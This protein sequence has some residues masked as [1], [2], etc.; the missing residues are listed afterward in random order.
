MEEEKAH[1]TPNQKHLDIMLPFQVVEKKVLGHFLEEL[2]PSTSRFA[3]KQSPAVR[4]VEAAVPG[5]L[6]IT[7]EVFFE[8]TID[9]LACIVK[10][11]I[12]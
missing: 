7:D 8:R 4:D 12:D 10:L 5:I 11:G 3:E 1:S 6:E 2:Q 9:I